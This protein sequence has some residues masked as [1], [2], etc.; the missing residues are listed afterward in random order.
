MIK[1][2]MS[3]SLN[4]HIVDPWASANE[5]AHEYGIS[6]IDMPVGKYDAIVLAVGHQA[7]KNLDKASLEAMANGDLLLFDIKGVK[8]SKEFE[9]YWRL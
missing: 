8:D 9:N 6:L 1:E 3:Y 4:V 2:L 5:V 7:Y